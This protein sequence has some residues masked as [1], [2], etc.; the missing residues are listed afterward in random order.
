MYFLI[1]QKKGTGNKKRVIASNKKEEKI[2]EAYDDFVKKDINC[3]YNIWFTKSITY[4]EQ[5]TLLD[6][7]LSSF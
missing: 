4:G 7:S 2:V 3:E 5:L 6:G 1:V